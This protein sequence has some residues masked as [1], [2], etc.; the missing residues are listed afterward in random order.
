MNANIVGRETA[1]KWREILRRELDNDP[2]WGQ[3]DFSSRGTILI[4]SGSNRSKKIV[5][6]YSK[7]HDGNV[8]WY[9]IPISYWRNWDDDLYLAFLF[10]DGNKCSFAILSPTEAM[11]LLS[12]IPPTNSKQAKIVHVQ[13]EA[14]SSKGPY[15][16]QWKDFP[17]KSK[18]K[19]LRPLP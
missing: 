15:I 2:N 13:K 12:K 1:E 8:W 4:Y 6:R 9:D 16:R 3:L 17:L 18:V 10:P 5:V 14:G 19:G 7:L 11:E